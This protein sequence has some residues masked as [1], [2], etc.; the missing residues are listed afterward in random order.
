MKHWIARTLASL[1][2][3][4][5]IVDVQAEPL[6]YKVQFDDNRQSNWLIP[7]T[8][9]ASS[10]KHWCPLDIGTQVL[11][12]MPFNQSKGFVLGGIW[13]SRYPQ[14]QSDLDV[15]Y[16]EFADGTV[17]SYHRTRQELYFST[18]GKVIGTAQGGLTFTGDIS[19]TGNVSVNGAIE[20]NTEV[21]ANGI[22]LTKHQHKNVSAGKGISGEPV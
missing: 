6:R 5:V 4:G 12:L 17:M 20:S 18:P 11:V 16:R 22:K 15:F 14:P 10:E 1:F 8:L 9:V 3:V 13:Q 2:V 21:T 19:I 7:I